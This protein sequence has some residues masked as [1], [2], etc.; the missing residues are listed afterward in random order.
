MLLEPLQIIAQGVR[1]I[2]RELLFEHVREA[3]GFVKPSCPAVWLV[4]NSGM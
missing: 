1:G 2:G 4:G 3:H